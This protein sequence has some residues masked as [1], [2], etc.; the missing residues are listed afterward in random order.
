MWGHSPVALFL[1][2]STYR[3]MVPPFLYAHAE[4]R[5]G[6]CSVVLSILWHERFFLNFMTK[7]QHKSFVKELKR[8]V[9]K[10]HK[11]FDAV[12]RPLL[13]NPCFTQVAQTSWWKGRSISIKSGVREVKGV[14][15]ANVFFKLLSCHHLYN[16]SSARDVT[17]SD[18]FK[19]RNSNNLP[20]SLIKA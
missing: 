20:Q 10:S 8:N 18:K 12:R 19:V 11:G 13:L 17:F 2:P 16:I 7:Q 9:G 14:V 6:R 5:C 4:S 15:K 1:L 3:G